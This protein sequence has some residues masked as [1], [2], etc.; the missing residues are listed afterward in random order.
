M[1]SDKLDIEKPLK[2]WLLFKFLSLLHLSNIPR[3]KAFILARFCSGTTAHLQDY[4]PFL[5]KLDWHPEVKQVLLW[6]R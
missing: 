1:I 2:L 4:S 5:D 6:G 3:S